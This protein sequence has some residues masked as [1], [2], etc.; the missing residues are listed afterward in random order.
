MDLQAH[1][2][3]LSQVL[4]LIQHLFGIE[5]AIFD[6]SATLVVSSSKYLKKKGTM[7]HKPSIL[8]VIEQDE[9]T[10]F[11]PGNMPSCIGCRFN[12]NCPATLE[13][14]KRIMLADYPVG[15][16]S[17]SAF[18]KSDHDRLTRDIEFFKQI[19]YDFV[20][21]ISNLLRGSDGGINSGNIDG[22]LSALTELVPDGLLVTDRQGNILSMNG[23]ALGMLSGSCLKSVRDFL[24]DELVSMIL[25]GSRVDDHS[26]T[27]D[28]ENSFS[29]S[30]V[31]IKTA[32]EVQGAAVRLVR[33][34][35]R[36]LAKAKI[37]EAD[38]M[39][40]SG[41][42]MSSIKRRMKKVVNSPSSVFISGETGTGKGLLAKSIHYESERSDKPFVTIS[43]ANIPESL[44]ESELFGYE[45]GAFT[46]ALKSGKR[47]KLEMAEGGTLFLDE[48]SEMPM[49]MQA[50]LLNVL[51][52]YRFERVGGTNTVRVNARIISASNADMNQRIAENRFRADL[53]YR[54]NVINIEML[55]L[56]ERMEDMPELLSAFL[57]KF[58]QRLNSHVASFSQ[59]VLDLFYRY[60]WPGNIRQLENIVEYC[61]NMA[62]G[63]TVKVEDLPAYF[64]REVSNQQTPT[65]KGMESATI[66]EM[67]DHYGWDMKGKSRTAEALGI[68]LRTLYRKMDQAHFSDK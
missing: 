22:Y 16:L 66:R 38:T 41:V 11:T 10:V 59:E 23:A 67:L 58:N 63:A 15:V 2:T 44:F 28:K 9:V 8:E 55:P 21:L 42:H 52:D 57:A 31:P 60:S 33:K 30:A 46:G 14:L 35:G 13:I 32:G 51:Q 45:A 50:K 6:N 25:E 53:F 29:V 5:S 36:I 48:I 47:G 61:V 3:E 37:P 49:N 20:E 24:P 1:S 4:Q 56:R 12:G 19:I 64:L 43:C 27:V 7:V 17:F 39:Q 68:S 65:L 62:E 26:V 18:S 54:L 40:G 34:S